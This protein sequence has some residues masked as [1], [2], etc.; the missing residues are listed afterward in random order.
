LKTNLYV[1]IVISWL[2]AVTWLKI[3]SLLGEALSL[4]NLVDFFYSKNMMITIFKNILATAAGFDRTVDFA[5]DRIKKGNSKELLN[6]IR[7][8]NDKEKRNKLK[9]ELPSICFSGT[10]SNRSA[11]GLKKHSGFVCLDFDSFPD[12]DTIQA[13]RDTVQAWEYTYA[14]FTSPSGNGLK[15]LVRI[16]PDPLKHKAYFD[17][18]AFVW[19]CPYFDKAVSDVSRVCYESYDPKL[20]INKEAKTW[21]EISEPD[22][23]SIG[24]NIDECQIPVQSENRIISNLTIWWEKKFGNN[25]GERNVNMY[26]FANALNSFGINQNESERHL[27]QYVQEDFKADEISRV[28]K[29]AY[30][31]TDR[32]G[33]RFFEDDQARAKVEKLI[34]SGKKQTEIAKVMPEIKDIESA[35]ESVKDTLAI[36]DFWG[37]TDKGK[38]QLSPHKYKFFL[39][40]NQFCKFFPEGA[41]SY[42]FVKIDSNLL[43]DTAPTFIKDFVLDS[44]SERTDIGYAP[45]DFMAN[46]T[47]L[48][49]EDYLSM[50]QTAEVNL[51][52][53]TDDTCYLYF[54][55]C[56]L[57]INKNKVTPI[58]YID[59]DG[60]VWKKHVIDREYTGEKVKGGMYEDFIRLVT[61]KDE[62][63]FDSF[64]SVIGYLLH[65]CKTSGQNKAIIMNDELISDNPNGGS[66]KGMFCN[67]IN[68]MK[69][70]ATLDGKQFSFDKSF[71]YQTVGADTQVLVFDDVKKNFAFE[72]LF[73]LITEGITLEKKNKDAI[74]IPVSRSPKVVITTNYTIGGVGGSFERRKFEIEFS[75]YFGQN[76]TPFDEFGK[77]LFDDWNENEWQRFDAFM[78][79]CVQYY[80]AN[81]LVEHQ[82]INLDQRKFIKETA[83]EFV[84]WAIDDNLPKKIRIDKAAKFGEFVSEYKDF[85]RKLS[86]RKFTGWLEAYGKF[87]GYKVTQ[88]KSLYRWIT[89][90]EVSEGI[91]LDEIIEEF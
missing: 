67:A 90:G 73:S 44:L 46:Q 4:L 31:S 43:E 79:G 39:E 61:D 64:R 62:Q 47:R 21:V 23:E 56:A 30:R 26:R 40:Q 20:Y 38:V 32:H 18:I 82:S 65:S 6:R 60:F 54:K 45:Y 58:D 85:D 75:S 50:L 15:V 91:D 72:Q 27:H 3:L 1:C 14:L 28:V 71:P 7:L 84:E 37:Y 33:T 36:T 13:F 55:N 5:L 77:M 35:L 10:F 16:P 88:G 52:K 11:S 19:D 70:V 48:F 17:A 69:R 12:S 49:K 66:G 68:H 74:H 78:I 86:Q 87:N 41:M 81:G 29:S 25:K 34:R 89:F 9:M 83:S 59:L 80:L 53:D 42:L 63:R 22:E 2:R 51:K 57:Q 8:E 76:H 24:H